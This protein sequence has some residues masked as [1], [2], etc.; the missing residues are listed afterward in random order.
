MA[1]RF[2]QVQ[3]KI[4]RLCATNGY[5]FILLIYHPAKMYKPYE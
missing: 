3:Y 4:N 2:R 1:A 5:K